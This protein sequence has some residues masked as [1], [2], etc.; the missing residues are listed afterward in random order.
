MKC[1]CVANFRETLLMQD[2][3]T[4]EPKGTEVLLEVRAAGVCHSDLHIWEGGYDLGN[5]RTLS[6]KD[7]GIALPLTMGHETAGTVVAMGPQASGVTKGKNYVVFPWIGCGKCT[8]CQDGLENYC[9]APQYLG[10]YK[11]GGY[12]THILVPDGRYLFDIGDLDPAQIAPY[13]CSGITT[14]SALNKIGAHTFQK[15]NVVIMGAGGL[16]LMCLELLKAMGGK[17]AI[18][19]DIDPAKRQAALDAG[20]VAAIDGNAPD[21]AKQII[22]A[23]GGVPIQSVVDLVGAPSTTSIAFDALIKGG[24]LVIVGLFGGAAPWPIAFI[25]MKALSILGSYTGSLEEMR[26]LMQLVKEGKVKP[27]QVRKHALAEADSV[28]MSLRA[29]KVTGRA[30]LTA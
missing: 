27:I 4:P 1:Y 18:V 7:R 13:A 29:G 6:L 25:P 30:V 8:A 24:K 12:A 14:F 15:H 11:A 3:P 16:G 2:L 10:V 21:A 26:Q 28:L 9:S 23:N 22:A 19:V 5:G 20:A 17:G